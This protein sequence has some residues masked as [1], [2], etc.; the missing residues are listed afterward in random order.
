D[1]AVATRQEA[2]DRVDVAAV[3][4]A[5][6]VA[7]TRRLAALD[8]V[9]EAR[10]AGA[11]AGLPPLAGPGLEELPQQLAGLAGALRARVGAEV[12]A[13]RPVSLAGE[14]DARELLV[15]ADPDVG[16]GLI[17]AEADVEARPVALDLLL[18]GEQRLGFGLGHQELD[19]GDLGD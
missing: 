3:L 5:G 1:V 6:D 19:R 8:V 14:V 17:V 11:T 10:D 12:Q 9:V 16:V 15:E 4:L 18:L 7:D 2:G 13:C